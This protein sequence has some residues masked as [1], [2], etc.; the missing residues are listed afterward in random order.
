MSFLLLFFRFF[1]S[2]AEFEVNLPEALSEKLNKLFKVIEQGTKPEIEMFDDASSHCEHLLNSAFD[3]FKT[4]W[5]DLD[6]TEEDMLNKIF[7]KIKK[8]SLTVVFFFDVKDQLFDKYFLKSWDAL[9][10]TV[11]ETGG[12]VYAVGNCDQFLA[13][14]IK[15]KYDLSMICLGDPTSMIAQ[16]IDSKDEQTAETALF[17]NKRPRTA[18]LVLCK[19]GITFK[20]T[21]APAVKPGGGHRITQDGMYPDPLELWKEI[22][23]AYKNKAGPNPFLDAVLNEDRLFISNFSQLREKPNT[24]SLGEALTGRGWK[25]YPSYNE[26]YKLIKSRGRFMTMRNNS[27]VLLDETEVTE[28]QKK[29]ATTIVAKEQKKGNWLTNVVSAAKKATKDRKAK[30]EDD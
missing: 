19:G 12:E 24:V 8:K 27:M 26:T 17:Y 1:T 3:Q 29:T 4:S 25:S 14:Q 6:D 23:S 2:E 15:W 10:S 16:E 11:R 13:N 18:I 7:K 28:E 5:C 9:T 20:Y 21:I 30:E 22:R